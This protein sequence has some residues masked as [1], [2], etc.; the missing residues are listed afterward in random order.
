MRRRLASPRFRRRLAWTVVLVGLPA[1]LVV[2]AILIGN[3]GKSPAT[4]LTHERVWVSHEPKLRRLDPQLRAQLLGTTWRFVRTAVVRKNL[5]SAWPMLGPALRAGMTR[6][7][8]DTGDNA[9]VPYR[10]TAISAVDVLYSYEGDVALDVSLI[11]RPSEDAVAKT[12]TIELTRDPRHHDRWLVASWVPRGISSPEMLRSNRKLP[13]VPPVK[14][15]LAERWLLLPLAILSLI[16]LVPLGLAVR[17]YVAH[18]RA[19]RRYAQELDAYR[20]VS[21]PS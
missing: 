19:A 2:V 17:T 15:A 4:P 7:Q 6:K 11:G 18:R 21:K 20:S 12:F 9:V 1:T 10:A 14:A 13:P 3:T 5:D 16:L 8:W